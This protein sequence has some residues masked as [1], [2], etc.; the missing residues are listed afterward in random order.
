MTSIRRWNQPGNTGGSVPGVLIREGDQRVFIPHQQLATFA[1]Y[2]I[3][4]FE[5]H[6]EERA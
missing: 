4:A 2:A 3:D 6:R 5:A 1:D